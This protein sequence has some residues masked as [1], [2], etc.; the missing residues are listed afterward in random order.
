MT[1]RQDFQAWIDRLD[2]E[3][4]GAAMTLVDLLPRATRALLAADHGAVDEIRASSRAVQARC[5]SVEDQGFVLLA[6]EAPVAGD[7]R[8]LVGILRLVTA[9]DRVAALVRH[10]AEAADHVDTRLLPR[11]VLTTLEALS[12]HALDVFRRGVDAWRQR[13]GLA[14]HELDQFDEAVDRLQAQLLRGARR[15]VSGSA[16]LLVLG[17]L[18]RYFERIADH[19]V[20]FAQ[21]ATFAVT[22]TR[23]DVGRGAP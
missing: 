8:R 10:V 1:A 19:G 20:A 17:L 14:V 12:R 16:D 22:G 4:I 23:V 11:A 15:D 18:A 5:R 7:L 3:L 9:T 21:H 2:D 13:D 6:R